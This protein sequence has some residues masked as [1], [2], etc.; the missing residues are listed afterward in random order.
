MCHVVSHQMGANSKM[1]VEKGHIAFV[2]D[3]NPLPSGVGSSW[4]MKGTKMAILTKI[5]CRQC[6]CKSDEMH[7]PMEAPPKICSQ[8]QAKNDADKR[9]LCLNN[10]ASMTVDERLRRI[11][12]W[13][14][15][16]KP[17]IDWRNVRF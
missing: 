2:Q 15:D 6:N 5:T 3:T 4:L 10:L 11:E 12:E 16:Y 1:P 17:P 9:Q 14:Y 7:S 13:I 8:C